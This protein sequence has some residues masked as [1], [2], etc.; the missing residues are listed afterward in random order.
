MGKQ[1]ECTTEQRSQRR[2]NNSREEG[3]SVI[4]LEKVIEEKDR[5]SRRCQVVRSYGPDAPINCLTE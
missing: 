2:S 5:R 3:D 1:G 4:G